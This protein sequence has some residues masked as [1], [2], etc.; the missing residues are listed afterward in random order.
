MEANFAEVA[1]Y[2]VPDEASGI[3]GGI[4]GAIGSFWG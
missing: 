3:W 4:I 1:H 2:K